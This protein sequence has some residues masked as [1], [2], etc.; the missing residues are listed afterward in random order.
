[1]GN[2]AFEGDVREDTPG[3]DAIKA[4]ILDDDPRALWL[5]SWGDMNTIVRA[6]MSI[7]EQ[8]HGTS[9]W[10]G[11][12]AKV[13]EKVHVMGVMEGIGQDNSWLDH[14]RGLFPKLT[15]WRVPFSYGGYVD[16]KFAQP[17]SV[18]LFKVPWPDRNITHGNGPLM[19]RYM[20]YG[21]SDRKSVV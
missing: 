12:R 18:E 8:Y 11:V 5:L 10:E 15:F 2:V 13:C 16:A 17:D 14:G 1:M 3:S 9:E 6:L 4:A 21:Y 19:S 7:A 20:L